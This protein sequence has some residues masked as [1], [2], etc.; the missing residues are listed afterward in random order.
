MC[1]GAHQIGA[2]A[3]CPR[4]PSPRVRGSHRS[5]RRVDR[6]PGTIPACAGEPRR[7]A[8]S[9]RKR[10]DHPRVCG[11]A[12]LSVV[13]TFRRKGPSPRVRGSPGRS[14]AP[15]PIGGTIP[16]CAGEP[17]VLVTAKLG[18]GDHPRVCGGAY[19]RRSRRM[20][21]EGPSPRVRGSQRDRPVAAA[22]LGTIPACAGEPASRA[23]RCRLRRDHPRVCGGA[24]CRPR[25]ILSSEGPSP[26]VRGSR[27]SKLA[28]GGW[29]RTIPACAGEPPDP[30]R[31]ARRG[32]DHPRVC[33]GA[34]AVH[35][36]SPL[37]RGPSPRV[38][39]SLQG[40]AIGVDHRGTIPAC[41]GE[42]RHTGGQPVLNRDH[43]RVCGG[44][45]AM[46]VMRVPGTGPSPRVRGS[47]S[48]GGRS[49]HHRGTIPACA[50]EPPILPVSMIRTWDHP[51]VCGGARW[52]Q[53]EGL[54]ALGPSPRVRG[55][56]E[57]F[58]VEPTDTGTIPACAG[59]PSCPE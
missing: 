23:S 28:P 58:G 36:N 3:P 8:T 41:A 12:M 33:G 45:D 35:Q 39:G 17:A 9:R 19:P 56:L 37:M 53:E 47:P 26:R 6:A 20:S 18:L 27:R 11:G 51:R 34:H 13:T 2:V 46:R 7:S 40:I 1:G 30:S 29:V 16:A 43:P 50:G 49:V 24:R 48:R 10:G 22:Q 54:C 25:A 5:L 38:R 4:G 21:V 44:A 31:A 59:E 32:W 15:A 57:Q 52:Y 55:S 14:E 42:P